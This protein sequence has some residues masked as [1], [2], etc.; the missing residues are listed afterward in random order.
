MVLLIFMVEKS[1][2]IMVVWAVVAAAVAAVAAVKLLI[3][4]IALAPK[5]V[6]VVKAGMA[7]TEAQE[8]LVMMVHLT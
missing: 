4:Y 3:Y 6:T 2:V 8:E 1:L 7:V 5:V